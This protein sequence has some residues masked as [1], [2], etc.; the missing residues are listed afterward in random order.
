MYLITLKQF[1]ILKKGQIIFDK[2]RKSCVF[3]DA[4]RNNLNSL[5]SACV[6]FISHAGFTGTGY[7]NQMSYSG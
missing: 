2:F 5:I 6:Y 7:G 4:K 3:S 1:R